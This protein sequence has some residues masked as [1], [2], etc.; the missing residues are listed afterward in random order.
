MCRGHRPLACLPAYLLATAITCRHLFPHLQR[1]PYCVL[2]CPSRLAIGTGRSLPFPFYE[3]AL[4]ALSC[5]HTAAP[6]HVLP[7]CEKKTKNCSTF[8]FF[9]C[10]FSFPP[11]P[12]ACVIPPLTPKNRYQARY[13]ACQLAEVQ[14]SARS[15]VTVP[16]SSVCGLGATRRSPLGLLWKPGRQ[17]ATTAAAWPAAHPCAE[18][19]LLASS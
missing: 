14:P 8:P 1:L 15:T 11:F 13:S 16:T 2:E 10:I 17:R 9:F 6:V 19:L 3:P 7:L 12:F 18:C 5:T 4:K